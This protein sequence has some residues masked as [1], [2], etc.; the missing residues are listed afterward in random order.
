MTE[1][2]GSE[3][4]W[5][6]GISKK[7]KQILTIVGLLAMLL[8]FEAIYFAKHEIEKSINLTCVASYPY[9]NLLDLAIDEDGTI[10]IVNE[11]GIEKK[12]Q[13]ETVQ[14]WKPDFPYARPLSVA[15][16]KKSVLITYLHK[17]FLYKIDK[18]SGEVSKVQVGKYEGLSGIATDEDDVI[19]ITDSET[20]K[21]IALRE[22]GKVLR[23]FGGEEGGELFR[24]TDMA[25]HRG[26][27]YIMC[28]EADKVVKYTTKGRFK[29]SW[30]S[31]W[32]RCGVAKIA[33]DPNGVLYVNDHFK[34]LIWIFDSDGKLLGSCRKETQ[35]RFQLIAPGCIASG[36]DGYI[37]IC[38]HAIGKFE[39]LK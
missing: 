29:G 10:Y 7:Q 14:K 15:L 12:V 37:Y 16:T 22:D 36:R 9:T 32:Q 5:L 27:L 34:S 23:T 11:A 24:P 39:P 28:P 35:G 18:K 38:S 4:T 25:Y 17:S 6:P 30:A 20:N 8:V 3:K 13:S 21:V 26:H 31:S 33:V 2:K 19:Y 1:N